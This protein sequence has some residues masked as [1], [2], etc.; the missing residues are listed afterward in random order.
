MNRSIAEH[1]LNQCSSRSHCIFTL[2]V[3]SRSHTHSLASYTVSKLNLVDLAGSERLGKT[4]VCKCSVQRFYNNNLWAAKE[5]QLSGLEREGDPFSAISEMFKNTGNTPHN[6]HL[7][8]Y[9][10]QCTIKY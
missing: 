7:V 3:E 1:T 10:V 4:N 9:K 2:Y 8:L 6:R 5:T